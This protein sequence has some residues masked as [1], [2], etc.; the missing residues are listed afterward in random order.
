MARVL[1]FLVVLALLL[2]IPATALASNQGGQGA[3]QVAAY[4]VDQT[5]TAVDPGGGIA[6][7][8]NLGFPIS[9]VTLDNLT[10]TTVDQ[11]QASVINDPGRTTI[12]MFGVARSIPVTGALVAILVISW[13]S[14]TGTFLRWAS[15][16]RLPLI[17]LMISNLVVESVSLH[18]LPFTRHGAKEDFP[19][20]S[21]SG[22]RP[23]LLASVMPAT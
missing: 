13:I 21:A 5:V 11:H 6:V 7:E 8:A 15:S 3:I 23:K 17:F 10:V 16:Q 19:D 14:T 12:N 22:S 4:T 18:H 20:A 1:A 9:T 2:V